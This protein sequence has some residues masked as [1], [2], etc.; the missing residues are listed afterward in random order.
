MKSYRKD[1]YRI[2]NIICL[3]TLLFITKEDDIIKTTLKENETLKKYIIQK[4]KA[5]YI[6]Q[7]NSNNIPKKILIDLMIF[8][9]D[10]DFEYNDPGKIFHKYETANKIFLSVNTANFP[11]EEIEF[12]V[13]SFK[14]S[15]YSIKYS[16]VKADQTE[17]TMTNLIPFNTNFLVTLYPFDENGSLNTEPKQLVFQF[18]DKTIAQNIFL[19]NFYSLNCAYEIYKINPSNNNEKQLLKSNDNFFVQDYIKNNV[20][21]SEEEFIYQ[22]KILS[23]E[24]GTY[25]NKMCMIYASGTEVGEHMDL[26][27]NILVGDNVPQKIN[28]K[29]NEV[30]KIKYSYEIPDSNNDLAIKF[31]LYHRAEYKVNLYITTSSSPI[32]NLIISSNQQ[33]II[34]AKSYSNYCSS[35]YECNLIVEIILEKEYL[36]NKYSTLEVTIKSISSV[37]QYPSYLIKNKINSEYLNFK[38]P[39]YYYSDIGE[40]LS[41]EIII[42]YYRGNG[43]IF[44]KIVKKG[45]T[46]DEDPQWRGIYKFPSQIDGTLKYQS[47]LKKLIFTTEDTKDCND[48]CYLLLTVENYETSSSDN[49]KRYFGFDILINTYSD[50]SNSP[51]LTSLPL[52]KYVVGTI[53]KD[54]KRYYIIDIP[55]DAEKVIFDFQGENVAMYINIYLKDNPKF[56]DYKYPTYKK[57]IWNYDSKNKTN[58]FEI[59]KQDILTK[60]ENIID[61]LEGLSLTILVEPQN[62]ECLSTIYTLKYHLVLDTIFNIYEIYSDQQTICETYKIDSTDDYY[63]FYIAK[64]DKNDVNYKLLLYPMLDDLSNDFKIYANFIQRDIYD[65]FNTNQLKNN[66]PSQESKYSNIKLKEDFLYIDLTDKENYYLFIK[67]QTDKKILVKMLSTFSTFDYSSVPNPS[68]PQLYIVTSTSNQMQFSFNNKEDILINIVSV[69]GGANIFWQDEQSENVIHRLGGRDD[70]LS[71][72]SPP[73]STDSN[74]NYNVL[75]I[76]NRNMISY[77]GSQIPGGFIFYMT[78][79]LRPNLI[80]FDEF[81]LGKSFNLNYRK[82]DFPLT[83]YFKIDN[84]YKDTNAFI[85]I[86]SIDGGFRKVV[87]EKEFDIFGTILSEST[88]FNI[89]NNPEIDI[90]KDNLIK[91]IYDS[92][93]R[94][95]LLSLNSTDLE[96]YKVTEGENS[97]LVLRISKNSNEG[98]ADIFNHISIEGTVIQ[99]ESLIPVTEKV[100]QFG[101]LK[102]GSDKMVYKLSTNLAQNIM[103]LI[104]SSNSNLLNFKIRADW[105]ENTIIHESDTNNQ[106]SNGRIYTHFHTQPESNNYIYLIISRKDNSNQNE[107][108]SNFV[109]KYINIDDISKVNLYNIN[110]NIITHIEK[111]NSPN[112]IHSI[113]I[114]PVNCNN[115]CLVTYFV[116]FILRSSLISNENFDNIA[117]IQSNGITVEFESKNLDVINNKINLDVKDISSDKDFA[118]IQVIAHINDEPIHEY[119]SYKSLFFDKKNVDNNDDKTDKKPNDK[120]PEPPSVNSKLI[121]TIVII[122]ALFFGVVITLVIV[123]MKY[124]S[125]NK[126]L[127]QQINHISFADEK[128]GIIN[129]DESNSDNLLT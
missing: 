7:I 34:E 45:K 88:L 123:I 69:L 52:E 91:G 108:L 19:F 82:T 109:F 107:D 67:I 76:Q 56:I 58:L 5:R 30:E 2:L 77:E 102:K 70:R 83:L 61:T 122:A 66:L 6:I 55:Y 78:F 117:V 99:D 118:Y 21:S 87:E 54:I 72:A 9:G 35:G 48:E 89:R 3:I 26:E 18:K 46:P 39:N 106:A 103:F 22:V 16:T 28:F 128:H 63:C 101:K 127:L 43:M 97:N 57:N 24:Q 96:K 124:N 126:N 125:K 81:I 110:D 74:S 95:C 68:T 42:N 93:K 1:I 23:L 36:Q 94:V 13:K 90:K 60:A 38:S 115:N 49:N 32:K 64:Y 8:S 98:N 65:L 51:P 114:E 44:G 25:N 59:T 113:S 116:N 41:G 75:N 17:L 112:P 73:E 10:V 104:F 79:Y 80:N 111:D 86:Y 85:T 29:K 37:N 40:N 4:E 11:L 14:S 129:D 62:N 50:I 15:Y 12:L 27:F 71:F 105:D 53:A 121:T 100:Y 31:I 47:Y 92:S 119:I 120:P 33:E 20:P 84:S